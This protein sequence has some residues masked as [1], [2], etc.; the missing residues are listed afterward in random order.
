V[1]NSIQCF[2]RF[3]GQEPQW[4]SV[5]TKEPGSRVRFLGVAYIKLPFYPRGRVLRDSSEL[6]SNLSL[7]QF[8]YSKY[9]TCLVRLK[10]SVKILP[11]TALV[12]ILLQKTQS[13]KTNCQNL[14]DMIYNST[15]PVRGRSE[16]FSNDLYLLKI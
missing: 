12:T 15:P 11:Q 5:C 4:W 9:F 2:Q 7:D 14:Y 6:T 13:G 8:T 10:S 16:R 1:I 3:R